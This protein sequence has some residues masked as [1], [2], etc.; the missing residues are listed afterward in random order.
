MDGWMD[1][2]QERPVWIDDAGYLYS[3]CHYFV[4]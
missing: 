4:D 3:L 1:G 2:W